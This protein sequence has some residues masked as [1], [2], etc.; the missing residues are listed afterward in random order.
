[1]LTNQRARKELEVAGLS[2]RR[3]TYGPTAGEATN[4]RIQPELNLFE[5]RGVYVDLKKST[6]SQSGPVE[7]C[8]TVY[9]II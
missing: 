6:Q 5:F 7:W 1:M 4:T 2:E 3:G 8:Q 9:C